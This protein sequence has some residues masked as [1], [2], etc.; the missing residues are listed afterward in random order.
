MHPLGNNSG[1]RIFFLRPWSA[2]VIVSVCLFMAIWLQALRADTSELSHD[3]KGTVIEYTDPPTGVSV[4]ERHIVNRVSLSPV[5]TD[6]ISASSASGVRQA[7]GN[8]G[9]ATVV[10]SNVGVLRGSE[11]SDRRHRLEKTV[12]RLQ[13]DYADDRALVAV[14]N[15]AEALH[16]RQPVATYI[17]SLSADAPDPDLYDGVYSP[18]TMRSA[19]QNANQTPGA[20][21]IQFVVSTVQIADTLGSILSTAPVTIDGDL[22]GSKVV[23]EGVLFVNGLTGLWFQGGGCVIKNLELRNGNGSAIT[24]LYNGGNTNIVQGCVI[25]DWDGAGINFNSSTNNIIGGTLQGEGNLIYGL[26]GTGA[27]GLSLI[28]SSG[29]NEITGNYIGTADGFLPSP[30]ERDGINNESSFQHIAYNVISG[31]DWNGITLDY[32]SD[33][34]RG[35]VI[36]YNKIGTTADGS[37]ALGNGADQNGEGIGGNTYVAQDTIRGNLVS[38]N[39]RN[40]ILMRSTA[41]VCEDN[42]CGLD[43]TMQVDLGNAYSGIYVDRPSLLRNNICGANNNGVTVSNAAVLVG[44]TLGVDSP[45]KAALGNGPDSARIFNNVIAANGN[46][47]VE[48]A[49]KD[50]STTIW[51]AERNLVYNNLIGVGAD[52]STQLPNGAN[53]IYLEYCR[54]NQIGKADSGNVIVASDSNGVVLQLSQ[55]NFLFGNLIG[56]IPGGASGYGNGNYGILLD[57][58]D[59]NDIG[60]VATLGNIVVE[61][62]MSG[63]ALLDGSNQN[64][65]VGNHIGVN[66]ALERRGNTG[67]GILVVDSDSNAI[68]GFEEA[69][70]NKVGG[71]DSAGV[72]IYNSTSRNNQVFGNQIGVWPDTLTVHEN[73]IGVLISGGAVND[74]GGT[75]ASYRN[76]IVGNQKAGVLV[77]GDSN[78]VRANYISETSSDG[79]KSA[80]DGHGVYIDGSF[81]EVG[82][83]TTSKGNVITGNVGAGV[84]V[85][86]GERNTIRGNSIYDNSELGIDLYPDSVTV[87]DSADIDLGP[88]TLLNYPTIDSGFVVGNQTIIYGRVDGKDTTNYIVEL[89]RNDSCDATKYGEGRYF[90]SELDVFTLIQTGYFVDT[91]GFAVDSQTVISMT[92]TDPDGNT[93]EFSSCWPARILNLLDGDSLKIKNKEF[94]L[95]RMENDIPTLTETELGDYRTDDSGRI[96]LSLEQAPKGDSLKLHRLMWEEPTPK[97]PTILPI[98]YRV[99]LDNGKFHKNSFNLEFTEM[100]DASSYD[101]YMDHTTVA[102]NLYVSIEFDASPAYVQSLTGAFRNMCNF[103]YDVFDGQ[104]VIDSV[105]VADD[106]LAWAVSDIRIRANNMQWPNSTGARLLTA[107]DG[108]KM[109][110]RWFGNADTARTL[111]ITESPLNLAARFHFSTLAHELGHYMLAFKDE[112]K[113]AF[114]TR[115][116]TIKNYGYM[117]SQYSPADPNSSEL[118]WSKQYAVGCKNTI[119]WDF[120]GGSCWYWYEAQQEREY[121]GLLAPIITP[122]ERN[123]VPAD[124]HFLGP[125]DDLQPL[126]YDVGALTTVV[127]NSGAFGTTDRLITVREHVTNVRVPKAQVLHVRTQFSRMIVQGLTS[128]SGEIIVL[129]TAPTDN[130]VAVGPYYISKASSPNGERGWRSGSLPL[131]AAKT[132]PARGQMMSDAFDSDLLLLKPVSGSFPLIISGDQTA[133]GFDLNLEFESLF[134]E[135]PS[136]TDY[137]EGGTETAYNFTQTASAYTTSIPVST[138][139]EGELLVDAVDADTQSFF[140]PVAYVEREFPGGTQSLDLN[141]S[142]GDCEFESDGLNDPVERAVVLST[143][144]P[145]RRDG[146]AANAVQAGLAHSISLYPEVTLPEDALLSL[147][148]DRSDLGPAAKSSALEQ[149]LRIHHWNEATSVWEL[150]GGDVDTSQLLVNADV[151]SLGTFALFTTADEPSFECGDAD[152]NGNVNIAD[153]VFLI[154]YIFGGPAPQSLAAANVDCSQTINVADAVYLIAYIFSDGYAPCDPDGDGNPGCF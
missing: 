96:F 127:D 118:S 142:A 126:N 28:L 112:Y 83:D 107:V 67:H 78:R 145:V 31:N 44:N 38:A 89:F 40:G 45:D 98:A 41:G 151:A 36:E 27:F 22:G 19:I 66:L 61:S 53:G 1:H 140:F 138:P 18:P 79:S 111:S 149:S 65:I 32:G 47:G 94:E 11:S 128:D 122:E 57:D 75:N 43:I 92:C 55:Q 35:N 87:N 56:S 108:L 135:T 42:I 71:N 113:Y 7:E 72:A 84:F 150:V 86:T 85:E 21:E 88:N 106:Y 10:N 16:A 13:G 119:Q 26:T 58:A 124:S 121:S 143:V 70:G 59:Q 134:S 117:D 51:Y 3:S 95:S 152:G 48:I 120:N 33:T 130:I 153:V 8:E 101:V 52:S 4:F 39:G 12:R 102:Y 146:L 133:T 25:H 104:L 137:P 129:G 30:N 109:P 20:D 69:Y 73:V 141:S 147:R 49:G 77:D 131:T 136:L 91:L 93:S 154:A 23:V 2:L 115:C 125:N 76:Y 144:Y 24:L 116:G 132:D 54:G 99:H 123:L 15:R 34:A 103:M 63:L 29:N 5:D 62:A 74:I 17:V 82:G 97:R 37:A 105:I 68:G 9:A 110:R 6:Q 114:G 64:N 81:N 60:G 139:R 148:Y 14:R 80:F 50:I 90:Q 46:N 100:T